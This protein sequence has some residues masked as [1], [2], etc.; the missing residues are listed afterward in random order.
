[1]QNLKFDPIKDFEFVSLLYSSSGILLVSTKSQIQS[2]AELLDLA[3]KK[4]G[5]VLTALPQLVRLPI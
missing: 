1:M 5:G 2:F 3:R 4:P